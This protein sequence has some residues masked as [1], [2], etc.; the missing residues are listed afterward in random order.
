[1]HGE[2]SLSELAVT[3]PP[4][5]L[6]RQFL[7]EMCYGTGLQVLTRGHS[8]AALASL[9]PYAFGPKDLGL[10]R[11]ALPVIQKPLQLRGSKPNQVAAAALGAAQMSYAPYTKDYAGVAVRT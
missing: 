9:L 4:C 7:W 8:P 11:G 10:Q 1:M 5:G 2:E 3:A 6:C